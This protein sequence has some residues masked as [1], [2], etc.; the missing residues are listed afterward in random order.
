MDPHKLAS[1]Q[2][3]GLPHKANHVPSSQGTNNAAVTGNI[4]Y[5]MRQVKSCRKANQKLSMIDKQDS[6]NG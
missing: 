5:H 6:S 2:A 1:L 4:T 3:S